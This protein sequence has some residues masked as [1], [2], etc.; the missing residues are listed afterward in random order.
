[1]HPIHRV[2][3]SVVSAALA[4]ADVSDGSGVLTIEN[5]GLLPVLDPHVD[6]PTDLLNG[7]PQHARSARR[8]D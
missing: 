5:D 1:M 4:N 3:V 7:V 8:R 6:V 2:G